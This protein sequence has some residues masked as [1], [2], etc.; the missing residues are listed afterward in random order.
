MYVQLQ[1]EQL[2]YVRSTTAH[3]GE[4]STRATLLVA[5]L[6]RA[7]ALPPRLARAPDDDATRLSRLASIAAQFHVTRPEA[8]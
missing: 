6:A 4:P 8:A 5:M 3:R 2:I 1:K 7:A